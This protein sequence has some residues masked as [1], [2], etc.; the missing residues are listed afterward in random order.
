MRYAII[1]ATALA[2]AASTPALSQYGQGQ[3]FMQGKHSSQQNLD[4]SKRPSTGF[5]G[6]S[7]RKGFGGQNNS[8]NFKRSKKHK[9]FS[10]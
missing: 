2:L 1:L 7:Q 9:S 8:R 3:R 4:R 10:R 6:S 5:G